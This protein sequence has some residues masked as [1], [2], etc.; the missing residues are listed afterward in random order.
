MSV[1]GAV[2]SR[3][4]V[5]GLEESITIGVEDGTEIFIFLNSEKSYN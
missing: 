3:V 2:G 4:Y 1:C 5:G